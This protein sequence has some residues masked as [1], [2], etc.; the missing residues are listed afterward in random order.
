MIE[1]M[2]TALNSVTDHLVVLGRSG[3]LAGIECVPD[4]HPAR[5]G[6][7]AGLATALRIADGAPVLLVAVDQPWIRP[8]DAPAAARPGRADCTPWFPTT[9]VPGR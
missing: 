6:P 2:A 8:R 5:R 7:L 1:W 4:D 9:K 3:T